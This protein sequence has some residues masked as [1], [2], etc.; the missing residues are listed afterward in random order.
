MWSHEALSLWDLID[1][2]SYIEKSIA[3]FVMHEIPRHL[4]ISHSSSLSLSPKENENTNKKNRT[5]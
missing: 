4:F 1:S 2:K 5:L 3:S